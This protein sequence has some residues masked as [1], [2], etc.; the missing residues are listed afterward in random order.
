MPVPIKWRSAAP[1]TLDKLTSL[2]VESESD[3]LD[4][5][6]DWPRGF[7][8]G[9]K[10]NPDWD[11]A[12]ATM[13]KDLVALAN[14]ESGRQ[15]YLVYGVQDHKAWR[16]VVG[17][18]QADGQ[19]YKID[20]ADFQTWA[21]NIFNPPPA[22]R[23]CQLKTIDGKTVGLFVVNPVSGYPHV[24]RQNMGGVLFEGQIWFR[25]GSKNTIALHDD[26]ERIFKG[27]EPFR[28]PKGTEMQRK[29]QEFYNEQGYE[30]TYKRPESK[31]YHIIQG[32]QPVY[33][34]GTRREAWIMMSGFDVV[35][36]VRPKQK[37]EE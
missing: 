23:Y 28:I 33:V 25:R 15:G 11:K 31:D 1:V 35:M 7:L 32:W 30:I 12:R 4:W 24:V 21:A 22:F 8:D 34:P 27:S 9:K 2:L 10:D 5:K 14:S 26:L 16:E 18:N 37:K 13:L 20:D 6:K 17:I 36:L 3:Y 29:M 19:T